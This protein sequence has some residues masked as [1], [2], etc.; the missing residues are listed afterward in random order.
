MFVIPFCAF[1]FQSSFS[2]GEGGDC[3]S[4]FHLWALVKVTHSLGLFFFLFIFVLYEL[5]LLLFLCVFSFRW[6]MTHTS[7]AVFPSSPSFLTILLPSW[8]LWVQL[9]SCHA[10]L[11]LSNFQCQLAS[12]YL[13]FMQVFQ[14]LLGFGSL[15]CPKALLVHRQFTQGV[16]HYQCM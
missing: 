7:L 16:G 5:L 3:L 9:S 2:W 4:S 12:F 8:P 6:S 11:P 13:T 14:R 15:E 10:F 1:V